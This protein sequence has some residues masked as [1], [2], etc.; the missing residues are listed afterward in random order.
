MAVA[1]IVWS[2]AA[3]NMASMIPTT[4]ERMVA[5]SSGVA[6][7]Y[8]SASIVFAK[9]GHARRRSLLAGVAPSRHATEMSAQSPADVL[10]RLDGAPAADRP[11]V[12]GPEHPGR[13]RAT[14]RHL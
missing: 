13:C 12:V 1:T 3:R 4:I 11:S 10:A 9:D 5:W 7:V 8:G 2:R 6:A 14:S